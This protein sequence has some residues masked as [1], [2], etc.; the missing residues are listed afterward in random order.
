MHRILA[1]IFNVVENIT[2]FNLNH[3]FSD[4]HGLTVT[5][6]VITVTKATLTTHFSFNYFM[7]ALHDLVNVDNFFIDKLAKDWFGFV[8][9]FN[10]CARK[11]KGE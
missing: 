5:V 10:R 6:T 8:G 3:S 1:A 9:C 7:L 11:R 4:I 2:S